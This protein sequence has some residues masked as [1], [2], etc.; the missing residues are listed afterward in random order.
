[1]SIAWARLHALARGVGAKPFALLCLFGLTVGQVAIAQR[2]TLDHFM[3]FADVAIPLSAFTSA[4]VSVGPQKAV[5]YTCQ[6]DLQS[7]GASFLGF[8][9]IV[10]LRDLEQASELRFFSRALGQSKFL[11]VHVLTP[12]CCPAEYGVKLS[13]DGWAESTIRL[14]TLLAV[15]TSPPSLKAKEAEGRIRFLVRNVFPGPNGFA[16]ERVELIKAPPPL[17][18]VC[19]PETTVPLQTDASLLLRIETGT[20]PRFSGKIACY[21]SARNEVLLP[22]EVRAD[23]GVAHVPLFVR[24]P[25]PH[26]VSFYEPESGAFTSATLYGDALGLVVRL[27][28]DEFEKQQS[29]IAPVYVAPRIKLEGGQSIPQSVLVSAYD[30]RGQLLLSQIVSAAALSAGQEK[31]LI[32]LP[33]LVEMRAHV[34]AEPLHLSRRVPNIFPLHVGSRPHDGATTAAVALPDEVTTRLVGG[35]IVALE[36]PPTTATLL[37]EDRFALWAFAKVPR[38]V[39]L[40]LTLF[41]IDQPD[42]ARMDIVD[43]SKQ[44]RKLFAWQARIGPIW[45]RFPYDLLDIV[46]NPNAYSWPRVQTLA[47]EAKDRG[48]RC[49]VDVPVPDS[50]DVAASLSQNERATTFS[51]WLKWLSQYR[52]AVGDKFRIFALRLPDQPTHS[53]T[54]ISYPSDMLYLAF[55]SAYRTLDSA[56]ESSP[57]LLAVFPP[58]FDPAEF[59]AH[60]PNAVRDWTEAQLVGLYTPL[61]QA[62]PDDNHIGEQID[63]IRSLLRKHDLLKRPLWIGPV[64]WSSHPLYGTELTQANYLV[65]LYTIAA[66]AKAI[67]V[68]WADLHDRAQNPWENSPANFCGLLDADFRPKPAAIACNLALFMLTST[69]PVAAQTT[70][71]LSVHTFDIELHSMRWPGKL[72]VAWT[73]DEGT[74]ATLRLPISPAGCYAFDYLGAQV[75]PIR[76]EEAL[77]PTSAKEEPTTKI[78]TFPVTHEPVYIWDV[79]TIPRRLLKHVHDHDRE[80]MGASTNSEPGGTQ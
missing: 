58:P 64:A 34:Y 7:T 27:S 21:T 53:R 20:A 23:K 28:V 57:S 66:S 67:R 24:T 52:R 3:P 55:K 65:R 79:T 40:P 37:G 76:V 70:D 10:P 68:F 16:L 19:P 78:M 59:K 45:A 9:A 25:G 38:E 5:R 73:Q 62:S 42:V 80:A 11:E 74:S 4:P 32:P 26:T 72:Y 30:H 49:I 48:L 22:A 44:G 15:P 1:M 17:K 47:K 8:E 51:N 18:L 2:L 6:A 13:P 71:T 14:S 46:E 29:L 31:I 33:G 60:L 39:R 61:P 75:D 12:D 41:G 36:K 54:R 56:G 35:Y 69:K 43:L 77:P 63:N 50:A